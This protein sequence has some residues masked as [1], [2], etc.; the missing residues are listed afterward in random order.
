MTWNNHTESGNWLI[1]FTGGV[2][3]VGLDTNGNLLG[4]AGTVVTEGVDGTWIGVNKQDR[5]GTTQMTG[6]YKDVTDLVVSTGTMATT[7]CSK[8]WRSPS[9]H[10][11]TAKSGLDFVTALAKLL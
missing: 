1:G 10:F 5:T 9:Q 6:D 11:D 2:N 8:T 7:V 4:S 3:I